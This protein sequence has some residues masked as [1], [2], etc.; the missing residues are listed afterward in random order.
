MCN[1]LVKKGSNM[2]EIITNATTEFMIK[3]HFHD[4]TP[5]IGDT[6]GVKASLSQLSIIQKIITNIPYLKI[7]KLKTKSH[8]AILGS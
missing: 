7:L 4:S 2:A 5:R 1:K 6:T 3:E 8:F